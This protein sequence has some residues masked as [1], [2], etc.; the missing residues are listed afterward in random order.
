MRAHTLRR[1]FPS[2]NTL[3]V[4]TVTRER[5]ELLLRAI[6]SV[7]AQE[8]EAPI[9]HLIIIDDC[10]PTLATLS[11]F[12]TPSWHLAWRYLPRTPGDE[13]GPARCAECL[14]LGVQAL[15][16]KWIAFLDD[17]NEFAADHLSSL[18]AC[19]LETGCR[20]V[21]SYMRMYH[22]DARPFVEERNPW[23]RDSAESRKEYLWM[24]FRG[25]RTPGDNLVRD[26][27]DPEDHSPVDLGEWLLLREL[28]HAIPFETEYSEDDLRIGRHED[29]KFLD[30]L[31]DQGEPTACT[32]RPTLHYYLGGMSTCHG[33]YENPY[34]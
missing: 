24:V 8:C 25:V 1:D 7:V 20:A 33:G 34:S 27:M 9:S 29:D 26:S 3:G 22:R 19:A 23:C 17:D 31:R 16:T 28:L 14:N 21:H 11:A 5:P 10:S 30:A 15:D 13:T 18:L 4:V 32:K 12:R 2:E 6:R